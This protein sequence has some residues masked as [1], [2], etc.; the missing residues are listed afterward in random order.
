ML[1][2]RVPGIT[3]TWANGLTGTSA[4]LRIRSVNSFFAPG[5][6]LLVIDGIAANGEDYISPFTRNRVTSSRLDDLDPFFIERIEVLRGPVAAALYGSG[7]AAGVLRVTT[8]H[9]APGPPRW[10]A[11][12]EGA[13]T[14]LDVTFPDNIEAPGRI[15]SSGAAIRTCPLVSIASGYCTQDSIIGWNPLERVSPFRSGSAQRAGVSVSGGGGG[16]GTTFFGGVSGD[17]A[18]GLSRE[19]DRRR[20]RLDASAGHTFGRRVEAGV[21]LGYLRDRLG[22]APSEIIG[23]GLFG[24][25]RDDSLRGYLWTTP[26]QEYAGSDWR[27]RTSRLLLGANVTWQVCRWLELGALAGSDHT[28]SEDRSLRTLPV[29]L[30]SPVNEIRNEQTADIADRRRTLRITA[31]LR[32]R[33]RGLESRTTIAA[34]ERRDRLQE[35]TRDLLSGGDLDPGVAYGDRSESTIPFTIRGLSVGEHLA[36]RELALDLGLRF[37]RAGLDDRPHVTRTYP[38]AELAWTVSRTRLAR[39]APALSALRLSGGFGEAGDYRSDQRNFRTNA[40]L[41]APPGTPIAQPERERTREIEVGAAVA[42]LDD[43]VR[44]TLG[45]YSRHTRD[46]LLLGDGSASMGYPPLLMSGGDAGPHPSK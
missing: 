10:R 44:L 33:V 18:T 42:A 23:Y 24:R 9:G 2:G 16:G 12:A 15:T 45:R 3:A 29:I 7:A 11:F 41:P 26:D 21:H 4:G 37:E 25:A 22:L 8:Q 6:P 39:F 27:Q 14:P 30:G 38:S 34:D 31:D 35:S 5:T 13:A 32:H 1:S 19:S 40:L 43:R 36:H 17:N 46:A 28:E 20:L